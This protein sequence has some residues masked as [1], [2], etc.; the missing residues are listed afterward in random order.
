MMMFPV[1]ILLMTAIISVMV[2]NPSGTDEDAVI[3]NDIGGRFI[4]NDYDQVK[5]Y[6]N[7]T[8]KSYFVIDYN[9]LSID[10]R[11]ETT[12]PF[13]VA[14]TDTG[15]YE[16]YDNYDD[17]ITRKKETSKSITP[18][19]LFDSSILWGVLFLALGVGVAVGVTVLGT[20]ISEF[21]QRLVFL[22]SIWGGVWLSLTALS[23]KVLFVNNYVGV[24]GQIAYLGLTLLFVFGLALHVSGGGSE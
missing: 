10:P 12:E 16:Y 22:S 2:G 13:E 9:G 11:T 4:I 20:G 18:T 23:S 1:F 21:A 3:I 19:D 6:N 8:G 24:Y 7:Y 17:F 14:N 5:W 15:K